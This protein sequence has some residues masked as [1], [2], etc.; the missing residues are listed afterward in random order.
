MSG[1]SPVKSTSGGGFSFENQAGA[2]LAAAMLSQNPVIGGGLG[3]P[4]EISFQVR[5]DGLELDDMIVSFRSTNE[6][7]RKWAV[8]VK[9][10]PVVD[11]VASPEFVE[12][13]WED[14]LGC[15]GSGF[16]AERDY[17]GLICPLGDTTRRHLDA[18]LYLAGNR[19]GKEYGSR[20]D[21]GEPVSQS[22]FRLWNSFRKPG[23]S[24]GAPVSPDYLLQRFRYLPLD[25][26]KVD[27]LARDAGVAFCEDALISTGEGKD[28]WVRLL[29]MIDRERIRGGCLDRTTLIKQLGNRFDFRGDKRTDPDHINQLRRSSTA[30]MVE[31]WLSVGLKDDIA[32]QLAQDSSV[33]RLKR[34][35][36]EEGVV[37]LAGEM[38]SGKSLAADRIHLDDIARYALD[39]DQAVP[40]FLRAREVRESLE[41]SVREDVSPGI[42][43]HGSAVR[44][45]LDGLDEV[46]V[47][48][49]TE[50]LSEARV[51]ARSV[52]GTRVLIT[53]R[54]GFS[55]RQ[56]EEHLMPC[57][58]DECLSDLA[59]R[60]V[61][62]RYALFNVPDPVEEAI[63][64]PLFAI[65]AL[66]LWVQGDELPSSR[67][68]FLD[69]F[70]K[71][72]LQHRKD[73]IMAS[74][75]TL[76]EVAARSIFFGG[77]LK[78]RD[79]D[80]GDVAGLLATQ[81]VV[82]DGSVLRFAL[83]VFEQYFGAHALLRKR[84]STED[85]VQDLRFFEAWRYAFVIAVGIGTWDK[86]S[87]L[88]EALG[89]Y[90][91]GAACWV[92]NQA[93]SQRN[94]LMRIGDDDFSS[95]RTT[96]TAPHRDFLSRSHDEWLPDSLECARRLHRALRTWAE[97]L[98][99][100]APLVGIAD[101][102]GNPVAVGACSGD[103][104]VAAGYGSSRSHPPGGAFAFSAPEFESGIPKSLS[105]VIR[106]WPPLEESGWPW[107]WTMRWV[108]DS[109]Q[110]ILERKQ[111]PAP[112]D[113]PL[114]LEYDWDLACSLANRP[115]SGHSV[116][117][118][119]VVREGRRMLSFGS[120]DP[121]STYSFDDKTLGHVELSNFIAEA[122]KRGDSPF[123]QPWPPPDNPP[124]RWPGPYSKEA[125]RDL[126]AGRYKSALA[127]YDYI[128]RTWFPKWRST[129]GWGAAMPIRLDIVL[130]PP[131]PMQ[132]GGRGGQYFLELK[133]T[134]VQEDEGLGVTIA[135]LES[136][137]SRGTWEG[138][139]K[140]YALRL[141][142]LRD[143]RPHT[144]D[145]AELTFHSIQT[146]R[147]YSNTPV[148]NLAYEWIGRD[149]HNIGFLDDQI[150]LDY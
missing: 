126:I 120:S 31:G 73:D 24:D 113:G 2:Y 65:I 56:G 62:H 58:T 118:K 124:D 57:L 91:P 18:L 53:A 150:R 28:L 67:A 46:G 47:S 81:M 22:K 105:Y 92:I 127:A 7:L 142:Q 37:V 131:P 149:L 16:D 36:P 117:P 82:R 39:S 85:V 97:W 17:V 111:L 48:R 89:S 51:L 19:A 90:W 4:V 30:R 12:R 114:R 116:V 44:V 96:T 132:S 49:G 103:G 55:L 129:L 121:R 109:V 60:L 98:K 8:S 95:F 83:P 1:I 87:D 75:D 15:A 138:H 38:G 108:A 137:E 88:I 23:N 106:G 20:I 93:I 70:V 86:I 63:R 50:L 147:L 141:K 52:P 66:H 10:M 11:K 71:Q 77:V 99:E 101:N 54:P 45:V 5:V 125:M 14:V 26:D 80:P 128:S 34:D 59:E 102:E 84:V 140:G 146:L 25:F 144:A 27:S 61:G 104:K 135:V 72:S 40:V 29:D 74:L 68:L 76:A 6:S 13:A 100:V 41:R 139:R 145:W 119:D 9:S 148:T 43:G 78:E 123:V 33:G 143:L 3:P 94:R 21:R 107:R 115:R 122:E 136:E 134:P 32:E 79:I 110:S 35:F 69:R 42:G 130:T 133:E 112:T 64:Y